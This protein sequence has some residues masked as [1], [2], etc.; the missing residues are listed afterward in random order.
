MMSDPLS[1]S[2]QVDRGQHFRLS[3]SVS[4]KMANVTQST[5]FKDDEATM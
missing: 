5:I 2:S 1:G 3:Q 4:L